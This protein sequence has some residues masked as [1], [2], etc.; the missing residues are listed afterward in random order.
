MKFRIYFFSLFIFF[1][2]QGQTGF[3]SFEFTLHNTKAYENFLKLKINKAHYHLDLSKKASQDNGIDIYLENFEDIIR[4]LITQDPAL[5]QKLEPNEA[6]RLKALRALDKSSPYYL[7]TQ[8]EVKLQW[9]IVKLQFGDELGAFWKIKSAFNLLKDNHKKFPDFLPN[10]KT[11]GAFNILIGSVPAKYKWV[12]N[13]LGFN[14]NIETGLEYLNEVIHSDSYVKLEA[15]LYKEYLN[16]YILHHS[17][18][19]FNNLHQLLNKYPDNLF[20]YF[21]TALYSIKKGQAQEALDILNKA[22]RG[23]DY[24]SDFY[25]LD[26]LKGEANLYL[27]NYSQAVKHLNKYVKYHPGQNLIKDAY[28]KLF[29]AHWLQEKDD[30]AQTYWKLAQAKGSTVTGP[31]KYAKKFLEFD[32]LPHKEITRARFYTDG[33][34]YRNALNTLATV[35]PSKL[36]HKSDQLEYWYRK[37][38][39]YHKLRSHKQAIY[40]YQK[41]LGESDKAGHYFAP[42][43]AL[44]LGYIYR[45]VYKDTQEAKQYFHKAMEYQ[46]HEYKLGIDSKAKAALKL[47]K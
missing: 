34:A 35:N 14:G 22:P 46:Q 43:S 33:G 38:R 37:A 1:L 42:N 20:V 21:T 27:G 30:E 44:Q 5:Y 3:A 17:N 10:K 12:I 15:T 47:L 19:S 9:A 32:Q 28:L 39:I 6:S 45:D 25:F 7:Y 41:T 23:K 40:Y 8:A 2:I 11:L 13:L 31:D 24:F 36:S 29:F 16:L 26:Y 18:W 4:L